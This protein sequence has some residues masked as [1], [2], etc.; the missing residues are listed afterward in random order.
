MEQLAHAVVDVVGEAVIKVVRL[1]GIARCICRWATWS[2]SS[3]PWPVLAVMGTTG[4]PSCR[5]RCSTSMESPPGL[6]LV[7]KIQG[8]H[9]GALQLQQLDG[10]VE[11]AFQV[12]GVHDV[13]NGVRTFT[14]DEVPG[15]DLLH[16]VGG[17]RVDPRQIHHRQFPVARR[18]VPS[19]FST[20]TPGQLPHIDWSP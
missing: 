2:S 13:Q 1:K 19:F 10:E 11:V 12:G 20:V 15:H 6:H 7:H 8:Q 3:S 16:G 14:D 4:T 9:Q 5:E 18:A 17:Q